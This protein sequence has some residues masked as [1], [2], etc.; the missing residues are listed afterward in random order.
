MHFSVFDTA[1]GGVI[2]KADESSQKERP[3]SRI[4]YKKV[5]NSIIISSRLVRNKNIL[6]ILYV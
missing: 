5:F 1:K 4:F 6:E 3:L 2:N